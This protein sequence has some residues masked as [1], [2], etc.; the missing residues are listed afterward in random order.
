MILKGERPEQRAQFL[1][2]FIKIA[3]V[4]ILPPF[5]LLYLFLASSLCGIEMRDDEELQRSNGGPFKSSFSTNRSIKG[6]LEG[7]APNNAY[8]SL[9]LQLKPNVH[10]FTG[11]T[12]KDA[13]HLHAV[14]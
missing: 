7:K 3:E 2:T 11:V 14:E 5:L 9:S 6:Q 10:S 12:T 8:V 4:S 1:N 13:R